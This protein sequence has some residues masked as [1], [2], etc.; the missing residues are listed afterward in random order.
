MSRKCNCVMLG[1]SYVDLSYTMGIS[2]RRLKLRAHSPQKMKVT[3]VRL[4]CE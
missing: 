4:I 2:C 3:D 1:R